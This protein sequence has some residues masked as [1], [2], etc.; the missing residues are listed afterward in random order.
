M[1]AVS[2]AVRLGALSLG[3]MLAACSGPATTSTVPPCPRVGILADAARMT[4]FRDGAGRDI[5]D[6]QSFS[7]IAGFSGSC[8]YEDKLRTVMV[9]LRIELTSERGAAANGPRWAD[10]PYFVSILDKNR[11]IIAQQDFTLRAEYPVNS[12][13]VGLF[14]E[15][16]QRLPLQA[17]EFGDA[18]EVLIGFRLTPDQLEWNRQNSHR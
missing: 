13:R 15:I 18:Y 1:G 2:T 9:D 17:G 14:D 3:L 11:A 10:L 8:Y 7:Q 16:E 5:T 12:I 4:I 6:V